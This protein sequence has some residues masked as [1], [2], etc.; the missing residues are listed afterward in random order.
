MKKPSMQPVRLYKIA[1]LAYDKKITG[2]SAT[3]VVDNTSLADIINEYRA[4]H[5]EA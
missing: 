4:K 5:A 1:T 2:L 3:S